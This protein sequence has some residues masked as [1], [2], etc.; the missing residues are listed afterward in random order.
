MHGKLKSRV[1][2][3]YAF[4][5]NVIT[6][7]LLVLCLVVAI[8]VDDKGTPRKWHTAI[9]G[10]LVPFASV[11]MAYW[12]RWSLWSTWVSIAICFCVHTLA[13]WCLFKYVFRDDPP[14]ILIWSPVAFIEAFVLL[15]P[16]KWV[17]EMLTGKKEII[18]LF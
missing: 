15:I 12:R 2:S 13:I 7:V 9:F 3:S 8:L 6:V 4:W 14:G 5:D 17:E 1:K 10:A 11:V 18:R 16:V